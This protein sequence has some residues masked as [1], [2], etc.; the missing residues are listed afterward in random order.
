[1]QFNISPW[2]IV[3]LFGFLLAGAAIAALHAAAG[4][5][6]WIR[7][8]VPGALGVILGLAVAALVA[9]VAGV[10]VFT[11]PP[12]RFTLALLAVFVAGIRIAFASRS[13]E[14][15]ARA[16]LVR[17]A[18]GVLLLLA[19]LGSA[20]IGGFMQR[21]AR[22]VTALQVLDALES[23]KKD[24]NTYPDSLDAL[25]PKYL[26]QIPRPGV[27]LL[28]N[29]DDHFSYSN[30]GDSYAL[31]FSS[32]LW[33]QC[34]YSPP[35]EFAAG[36]GGRGGAGLTLRRSARAHEGRHARRRRAQ[37]ADRGGPGGEGHAREARA[38]WILELS[39]GTA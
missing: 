33:V 3:T 6:L 35:Y 31:E 20:Q 9:A 22:D 4:A 30:Y 1:M 11:A 8:R 29:Q 17:F 10:Y 18:T 39:E 24:N 13:P 16:G 21:R 26:A 32:V 19:I 5:A 15:A 25:V 34:Q 2:P 7:S 23:Y 14:G 27:G 37:G 12:G 38:E 28:H 36:S